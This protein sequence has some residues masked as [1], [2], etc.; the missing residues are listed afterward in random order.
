[1]V[2]PDVAAP[3]AAALTPSAVAQTPAVA[4]DAPPATD[5]VAPPVQA[6]AP[7]PRRR[8]FASTAAVLGSVGSALAAALAIAPWLPSSGTSVPATEVASEAPRKFDAAVIPMLDDA[9][10]KELASYPTQPDY[11]ALALWVNGWTVVYGAA[12]A[13]AAKAEALQKCRMAAK[14]T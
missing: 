5:I 10:R 6:E 14:N 2:A 11:K 9:A 4:T 12:S 7:A 1:I 8:R 3:S 13:E